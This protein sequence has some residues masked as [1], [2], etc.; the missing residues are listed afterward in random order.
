MTFHSAGEADLALDVDS[1]YRF[2]PLVFC[3]A[4]GPREINGRSHIICLL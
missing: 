1:L 3:L 4:V 2:L